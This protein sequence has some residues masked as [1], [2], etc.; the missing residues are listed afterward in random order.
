M[1]KSVVII[2]YILSLL[3]FWILG[4]RSAYFSV[5]KRLDQILIKSKSVTKTNDEKG[6]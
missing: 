5:G 4:K 6:D 1:K 2:L 3:F